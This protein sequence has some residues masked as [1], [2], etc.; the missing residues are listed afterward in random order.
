M[1]QSKSF[2]VLNTKTFKT[3]TVESKIFPM[4]YL[5]HWNNSIFLVVDIDGHTYHLSMD[6]WEAATLQK[7]LTN[8]IDQLEQNYKNSI[9][10]V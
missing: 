10:G 9:E 6:A 7:Q 5:N 1:E 4:A 2:K 8:A 3:K